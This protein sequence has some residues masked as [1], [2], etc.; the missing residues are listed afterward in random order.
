MSNQVHA[1]CKGRYLPGTMIKS[2]SKNCGICPKSGYTKVRWT[3]TQSGE[4]SE[5]GAKHRKPPSAITA[6]YLKISKSLSCSCPTLWS[7]AAVSC[8]KYSGL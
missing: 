6:C 1:D 4:K 2:S 8:T 7:F 3:C 5:T